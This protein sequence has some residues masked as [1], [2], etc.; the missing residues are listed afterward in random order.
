[1]LQQP[2]FGRRLRQLRRQQER[3][4]ADL[5]G[6]GMSPTYLSRLESGA[7][8][9]TERVVA[10]LA[11]RLDVP[12]EAFDE[13]AGCDL[14]E[15]LAC[16]LLR[17]AQEGTAEVRALLVAALAEAG[18]VE[19]STRWH[20]LAQLAHL[21]N[22]LGEYQEERAVLAELVRLSDELS[23][24]VLQVHARLRFARCTRNLG[25]SAVARQAAREAL[26]LGEHHHVRDPAADLARGRLLLISVEAELGDL[27]EAARLTEQ[28]LVA[29]EG[30]TGAL[31]AEAFWTAAT[32]A[33]RQGDYGR[34][35]DLLERAMLALDSRDDLALWMRVRL[36]AASLALQAQPPRKEFA[37][38]LL[39]VLAPALELIGSSRNRQ[40]FVFLQAQLA[41]HQDR[42]ADA[43]ELCEQAWSGEQRLS[44]RDQVRLEALRARLDM[45]FGGQRGAGRLRE[46]AGEAEGV[47]MSDLAAELWRSLA[48]AVTSS[49]AQG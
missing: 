39:H 49:G 40:E 14:T 10:Y 8:P 38:S 24:T 5:T 35:F 29:L 37:E 20:A 11:E 48:E 17:S 31:A 45:H 34:A 23:L 42:M 33:T 19:P 32:V 27:A 6:P 26:S 28:V 41:F 3:S 2:E 44:Y 36:A 47:G 1:M 30:A 25:E 7:R 46:L 13:T 12:P 9:P 43:R 21:H 16:V 22:A 18:A 4:Q 15:A